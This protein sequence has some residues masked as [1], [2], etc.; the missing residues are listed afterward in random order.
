MLRS[1]PP[2]ALFAYDRI[3]Q[4]EKSLS[5]LRHTGVE[6]LYVFSDG[7]R[8][9]ASST[10]VRQVRGLV[11][12]IDWVDTQVIERESNLGLSGSIREGL[13]MLFGLYDAVIIIED[14]IL[15]APRFYRYMTACLDKYRDHEY[16]AT[17]TGLRYPFKSSPTDRTYDVFL[18]P[19]FSSWGWGTWRRFWESVDFDSQSLHRKVDDAAAFRNAGADM[20]AMV[21]AVLEGSLPGSWDVHCAITMILNRQWTVW[22]WWNMVENAG[23][24]EGEHA[25]GVPSWSLSWER[26]PDRDRLHLP[27]EIVVDEEVLTAFLSFFAD[28]PMPLRNRIRRRLGG[29][30][31]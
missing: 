8:D 17:V 4:L 14:D 1:S 11:G 21:Q 18:A 23:F 25:T 9:R 24:S 3:S 30:R 5:C 27:D 2:V 29:G 22:P 10:R 31:T 20:P 26:G 6:R 13:D 7:P 15:V 12:E 16:V 19:R 28:R